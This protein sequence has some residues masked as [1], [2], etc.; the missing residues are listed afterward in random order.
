[1]Q[2]VELARSGM[3]A[4]LLVVHP[5]T[6][7]RT[8]SLYNITRHSIDKLCYKRCRT[9]DDGQP[10]VMRVREYNYISLF[11]EIVCKLWSSNSWADSWMS[12][13]ASF[14]TR[15]NKSFFAALNLTF[16]LLLHFPQFV[17]KYVLFRCR[18]LKVLGYCG[19]EKM[20]SNLP[21]TGKVNFFF[22]P[23]KTWKTL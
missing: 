11:V 13:H 6:K 7:V 3:Q 8:I 20:Q 12:M 15:G 10:A 21:T 23:T 9:T 16:W 2:A 17:F 5:E 18:F 19:W 1:M 22:Y 4:S 14:G